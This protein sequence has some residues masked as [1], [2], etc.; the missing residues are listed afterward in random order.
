MKKAIVLAVAGVLLITGA[1]FG[2]RALATHGGGHRLEMLAGL[3]DLTEAQKQSAKSLFEQ[4]RAEAKP[5]AEQ[6]RKGH[7][8]MR[9]AVT[10][11]RSE[12]ELTAIA[13]RQGVQMGQ[14]AAVHAK[15]MAKFYAQLTPE[16]QQKAQKLHDTMRERMQSRF[17]WE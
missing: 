10:S 1:V 15:Q 3:L 16:Q 13:E 7:E 2:Q 8:E 12:S 11:G 17:G 4:A 6:L 5:I 14:L 9:E